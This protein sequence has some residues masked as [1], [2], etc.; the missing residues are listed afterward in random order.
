[1]IT[2]RTDLPGAST[3]EV[4]TQVSQKIEEVVNTI[5]GVDEVRSYS[6]QN[7]SMVFITF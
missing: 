7:M 6:S 3:E 5:N 1:M 2:I 4:E